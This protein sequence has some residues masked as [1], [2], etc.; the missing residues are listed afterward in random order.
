MIRVFCT[1]LCVVCLLLAGCAPGNQEPG[2]RQAPRATATSL[3][4]AVTPTATVA[5]QCGQRRV[6]GKIVFAAEGVG[7]SF[8]L[9][10]MNADGSGLRNL[11]RH[12][13]S[14]MSP[15]WSPD[16]RQI[17]FQ[18]DRD[19]NQEISVMNADGSG[20]RNLTRNPGPDRDPAWSPDGRQIAFYS[21]RDE[22]IGVFVMNTD[23]S[24][25]RLL[26]QNGLAPAWSPDS[27]RLV[28]SKELPGNDEIA[29]IHRDGSGELLLTNVPQN[30]L[31]R[32]S[33]T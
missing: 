3:V 15:S 21:R 16:G 5:R 23:G 28:F 25:V 24:G 2:A 26:A 30:D 14:D 17:V 33:V 9:F 8:D 32:G 1:L 12:A 13:G 7:G 10:V 4:R 6:S 18:T 11:T 22:G 20:L 19:G 31:M 27:T 29:V